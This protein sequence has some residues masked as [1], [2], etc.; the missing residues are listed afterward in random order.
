MCQETKKRKTQYTPK[1]LKSMFFIDVEW[2]VYGSGHG[3]GDRDTERTREGSNC[4]HSQGLGDPEVNNLE[5]D[6]KF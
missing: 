2:Y 3:G 5:R 4:P 6:L 1:I